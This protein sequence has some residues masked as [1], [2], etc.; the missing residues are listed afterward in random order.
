MSEACVARNKAIFFTYSITDTEGNILE[1]SDLPLGYI[2]G[3]NSGIIPKVETALAGCK[4]GDMVEVK[5]SPEE[6]FG[7]SDP[8]LTYTDDLENVPEEY[9]QMGAEVQFQNED[10][11]VR[12]FVVSKIENGKLTL[13]GNHPLSGK[14]LLFTVKVTEIRDASEDEIKNGRPQGPLDGSN[15]VH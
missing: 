6:G 7:A 4:V 15:L 2:H 12:N 11:E 9:R 1:R 14:D 3:A 5:L 10:G 13:D 8:S